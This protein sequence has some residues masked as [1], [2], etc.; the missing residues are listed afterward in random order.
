MATAALCNGTKRCGNGMK[1]DE[2]GKGAA[3]N[4]LVAGSNPARGANKIKDLSWRCA[5]TSKL[6]IEGTGEIAV[7]A[8]ARKPGPFT[9][10]HGHADIRRC[11][12][13]ALG[14]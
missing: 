9:S 11:L 3:V 7:L 14:S 6:I 8:I 1:G 2:T 5:E 4:R 12:S 13:G 10:C